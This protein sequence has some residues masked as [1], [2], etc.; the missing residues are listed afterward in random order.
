MFHTWINND[1]QDE[2]FS[3]ALFDQAL[4]SFE[5]SIS[6][7]YDGM[8]IQL[9]QGILKPLKDNYNPETIKDRRS[10]ENNLKELILKINEIPTG[11]QDYDLLGYV[12]EYFIGKFA[13]TSAKGDGQYYTPHEVSDL[14]SEI[15]AHHLKDRKEISI[16]D[17]TSGSGS[18]LLNIGKTYQKLTG[19]EKNI[20]YY[21]QDVL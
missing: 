18:L 10:T 9:Y 5:K 16:Y 7:A 12:Y 1:P 20:T 8:Y 19:K 15:I 21:A 6:E 3:L 13:S 4:I 17:P 14:M 2:E 11:K